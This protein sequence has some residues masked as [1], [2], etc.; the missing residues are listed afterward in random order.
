MGIFNFLQPDAN[1]IVWLILDGW[2]Y[3]LNQFNISFGQLVD[4]KGQPQ[5]EVRGGGIVLGF[6][7]ILPESIYRW[8]NITIRK[9]WSYSML[10]LCRVKQ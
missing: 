1:L 3:E 2:E 4:H 5:D 10:H 8:V 6:S 7:E 9:T